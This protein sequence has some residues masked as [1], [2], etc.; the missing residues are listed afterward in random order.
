MAIKERLNETKEEP[1]YPPTAAPVAVAA[2]SPLTTL[3]ITLAE[4]LP[5]DFLDIIK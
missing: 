4:I 1:K 5:S 3:S 2:P